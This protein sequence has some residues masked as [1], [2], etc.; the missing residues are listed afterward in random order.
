[1]RYILQCAIVYPTPVSLF[2][3]GQDLDDSLLRRL[4]HFILIAINKLK[5]YVY[6]IYSEYI[7][8]N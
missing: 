4:V 6:T 2:Y 3:T 7:D 8:V 1:M 5:V